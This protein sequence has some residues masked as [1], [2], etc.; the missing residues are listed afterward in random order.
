MSKPHTRLWD[1]SYEP[2][3]AELDEPIQLEGAH[4]YSF[5]EVVGRILSYEPPPDATWPDEA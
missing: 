5:E 3:Q 1:G 4:D 2:T